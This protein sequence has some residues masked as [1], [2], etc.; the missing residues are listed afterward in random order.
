VA[1]SD[2][3][4]LDIDAASGKKL[5][6]LWIDQAFAYGLHSYDP[7]GFSAV[8]VVSDILVEIAEVDDVRVTGVSAVV[9]VYLWPTN[10][11]VAIG[12]ESKSGILHGESGWIDLDDVLTGAGR[13]GSVTGI[14]VHLGTMLAA[15]SEGDGGHAMISMG[16]ADLTALTTSRFYYPVPEPT[17]AV[18]MLGGLVLLARRSGTERFA[19]RTG[20][21]RRPI[22]FRGQEASFR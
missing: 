7:S 12:S 9:P 8:Q 21:V 22:A 16:D 15:F 6:V 11:G 20:S 4:I 14:R 19:V 1:L 10:T 5:D 17:S 18:L 3:L 13:V 2:T